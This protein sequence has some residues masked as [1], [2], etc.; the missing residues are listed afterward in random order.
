MISIAD[1]ATDSLGAKLYQSPPT[2]PAWWGRRRRHPWAWF[3]A[4]VM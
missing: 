4:G 1:A 3:R 2:I